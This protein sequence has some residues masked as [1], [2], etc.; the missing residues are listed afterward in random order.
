MFAVLD[1]L[2]ARQTPQDAHRWARTRLYGCELDER[3]MAKFNEE[4]RARDL[5]ALPNTIERGDFFRWLPPNCDRRAALDRRLYFGSPLEFF[6][7]IVGNPPFGG[8][9]DPTIADNLDN[10]FGVRDGKK[11]KKETYAF[12]LIKSVDLLKPGGRLCFICSDTILTIPTML[13]LRSWLQD[14]CQVEV[15][16]VPGQFDDTAQTLILIRLIKQG[17]KRQ[18][19][20]VLGS[21]V[22]TSDVEATPNF[23]WRVDDDY[24]RYF[25]GRLLGA[26][27]V[28]SSGMTIGNNSLFLRKIGDGV[29]EEPYEFWFAQEPITLARELSRARLGRLSRAQSLAIRERERH[30]DTMRVVRWVRQ[31]TPASVPIPHEDYRYYNKSTREVVYA[32][33]R[34][35]VFWR[36]NGEYVYTYKKSG[37]WYLHGVGGRPYFGKEGLTWSLIAPRLRTRWLPPGYIL[38]SGAP[39]AFLRP[40]VEQDELF[41]IMG[42]TLTELCTSILKNVINHTR[43]IQSK[44]LE[45]LPYPDWTTQR[46]KESAIACVK[47]LIYSAK[48]GRRFDFDSPEIR[49][50]NELYE[51]R[52][53]YSRVRPARRAGEVQGLLDL[54]FS[55]GHNPRTQ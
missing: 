37:K 8:S 46:A 30:G 19:I 7:V 29:I 32:E 42:W 44:D 36:D 1:D 23:S 5:G 39:C 11:I 6:D 25:G 18:H 12:F 54:E 43:N 34:W 2:A 16:E 45:R 9:I 51:Y 14:R 50:L 27:L 33:P 48:A 26:K 52:E 47:D 28:A 13:G 22:R 4:W 55:D 40:G 17:W 15:S 38:D 35:V 21:R 49:A 20:H 41:F 31:E 53:G 24:A 10:I 3:A